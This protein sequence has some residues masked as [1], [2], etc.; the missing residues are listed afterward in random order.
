MSRR[1]LND[2]VL[3]VVL[4][5]KL[6][7]RLERPEIRPLKTTKERVKATQDGIKRT[8]ITQRRK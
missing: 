5:D 7:G 1:I 2:R 4:A 6:F 3:A 8:T